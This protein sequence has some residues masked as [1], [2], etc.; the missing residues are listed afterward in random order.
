MQ[1]PSHGANYQTLYER[2]QIPM[3]EKVYDLSENVNA[4]G[5]P[6]AI[7]EKWHQLLHHIVTYPHPEAEPLRTLLA[8]KHHVKR[9]N[10]LIGNGAAELLTFFAGRFTNQKVIIVHPTFSE[11]KTTLEAQKAKLLELVVENITDYQLPIEK[12]K[13]QMKDA[14]CLYLCNPNNPTGSLIPKKTIEELLIYGEA[15]GCEILVDEA[16]MD[17]TDETQSVIPLIEQYSNLTV[18][19]S[20]TKMY[21]IAGIRLGYFIGRKELVEELNNKLPHWHV[22]ALAIEIGKWCLEDEAFRHE[23]IAK[24]AEIKARLEHYLLEKQC[25]ITDSATNF[26]C[27]QLKE[28]EKTRDFYFYCLRKGVVLR[29]TENFYG[30]DGKWLRI[31]IKRKEAME[32]FQ[33]VMDEWYGQ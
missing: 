32:K 9:E 1:Y 10:L 17:W 8:Q 31:G 24:H 16:F 2:F 20:M 25:I 14:A 12:I 33:Q 22:N 13:K 28:P 27:F 3:P 18:L 7:K 21:G 5:F 26:L 23:S 29:H 6:A 19:R 11:Y 30:M 4:F 15:V